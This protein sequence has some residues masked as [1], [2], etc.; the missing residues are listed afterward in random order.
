MKRKNIFLT[1]VIGIALAIIIPSLYF[2]FDYS[3]KYDLG[4]LTST[5]WIAIMIT[6]WFII[7][8]IFKAEE[9]ELLEEK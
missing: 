2:L 6:L 9:L 7:W 5:Q 1:T 4:Y 8:V 3:I